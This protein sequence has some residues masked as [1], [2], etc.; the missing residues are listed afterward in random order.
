MAS[1]RR[2]SVYERSPGNLFNGGEAGI[3]VYRDT[4][5]SSSGS[6]SRTSLLPVWL[7][8]L[9]RPR[10]RLFAR[11]LG[12]GATTAVL[13]WAVLLF[14]GFFDPNLEISSHI[15][16]RTFQVRPAG[17]PKILGL[18][19][20]VKPPNYWEFK[21]EWDAPS[22]ELLSNTPPSARKCDKKGPLLLYVAKPEARKRSE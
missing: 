10:R 14:F 6:N 20:Y 7:Q 5:H 9:P 15:D 21:A 8:K 2:S 11:S 16:P 12:G 13:L 3:H 1:L 22:Y 19:N 18:P 17:D 4:P